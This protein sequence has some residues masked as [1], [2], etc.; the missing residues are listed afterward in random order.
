MELVCGTKIFSIPNLSN[1]NPGAPAALTLAHDMNTITANKCFVKLMVDPIEY[2]QDTHSSCSVADVD[3][4][5]V[6]DVVITGALNATNG[7]TAVFYWNVAKNTVSHYVVVDP[8]YVNG[9]PWGTGRVNLGDANGDGAY[10]VVVSATDGTNA[11]SQALTVTAPRS[12]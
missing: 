12:P 11:D 2:G 3:R 5:G 4:D 6:V 1:R 7:P 8:A 9:W 10:Q